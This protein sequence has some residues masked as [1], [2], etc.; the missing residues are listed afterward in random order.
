MESKESLDTSQ[1]F[2]PTRYNDAAFG[3]AF[4]A[5]LAAVFCWV[6]YAALSGRFHTVQGAV[7]PAQVSAFIQQVRD[8]VAAPTDP[9]QSA[10]LIVLLA[11]SAVLLAVVAAAGW[12]LLLKMFPE[13][14][15]KASLLMLPVAGA[16]FVVAALIQGASVIFPLFLFAM[17]AFFAFI[18]WSRADFTAAILKV[19][20]KI[21]DSSPRIYAIALA[22]IVAQAAWMVVWLLA[23]VPAAGSVWLP[24]LLLSQYWTVHVFSNVLY[25]TAAGTVARFY[26][27]KQQDKAAQ[28]SFEQACTHLFGSICLGSLLVAL[29]QT[30]KEMAERA[31]EQSSREGN[32]TSTALLCV[33]ECFLSCLQNL[34][35]IF[36]EFA[37]VYVAIYSAPFYDA[38]KKTYALLTSDSDALIKA[39]ISNIVTFFGSLGVALTCGAMS[40]LSAWRVQLPQSFIAGTFALSFIVGFAIMSV[41]SRI[42]EG[43][44]TTMIVCFHEEPDKIDKDLASAFLERKS[45]T[46]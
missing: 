17:F 32:S 35:Q 29:I 5:Q 41:V 7:H 8:G 1:R 33:A 13:M 26:F 23:L 11:L 45:L 20:V 27:G 4:L 22:T 25:V 14:M 31:K 15:V 46:T 19:V 36:N 30:L 9:A 34:A 38:A 28:R 6:G 39:N 21:Y 2:E 3:V 37:F 40:G 44:A 12:M 42:V 10:Y 18:S 16:L 43:G 24:V